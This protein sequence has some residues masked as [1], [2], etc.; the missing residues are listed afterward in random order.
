MLIA[1]RRTPLSQSISAFSFTPTLEM[2]R[3]LLLMGGGALVLFAVS[4]LQRK[5]SV[6]LQLCRLPRLVRLGLFV[7]LFFVVVWYGIP[8]ST[9]TGGFL[10]A[11]F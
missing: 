10:Y 6:R 4:L 2:P 9:E 7:F 11:Q 5:G 8:L 1:T 3:Q